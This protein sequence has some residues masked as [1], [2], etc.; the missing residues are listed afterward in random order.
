MTWKLRHCLVG[1]LPSSPWQVRFQHTLHM[2][3][4]EVVMSSPSVVS[5]SL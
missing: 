1:L 4:E 3:L 2:F 5:Q